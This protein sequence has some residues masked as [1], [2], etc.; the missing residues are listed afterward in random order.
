MGPLKLSSAQRAAILA[1]PEGLQYIKGLPTP[2]LGTTWIGGYALGSGAYGEVTLWI[3]LD[4]ITQKPLKTCAIKDSFVQHSTKEEGLYQNVYQQLVRK[5]FD[6][7]VDPETELG[8]ARSD[9]RFCK[10][11][12]LQGIM[13]EPDSKEEIFSVALYGY[14]RQ[15]PSLRGS[16]YKHWRLYMPLYEYSTLSNLMNAHR[17]VFSNQTSP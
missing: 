1:N 2:P 10:E 8:H 11:A 15:I 9:Q 6:F 16:E 5:G 12:Y 17:K 7:D 3:L 13:T 14:N 4:N